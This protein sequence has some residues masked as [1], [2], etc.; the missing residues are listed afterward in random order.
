MIVFPAIDLSDG[1]CVRLSQGDFDRKIVY[2]QDPLAVARGFRAAGAE[3]LHVVDLDGA[4][5]GRSAQTETILRLARDSGLNLQV[6]GGIREK[7][8]L[9]RLLSGGAA[10]VVIGSRA[11]ESPSIVERWLGDVGSDRLVLA[12]DVRCRD[13]GYV[14]A[15]RGWQEESEIS[16][17]DLLSVYEGSVLRHVICTDIERDGMLEGPN[18]VLYREMLERFPALDVLASG[19][20]SSLEDL[21]KLNETGVGG[22][23]VGKAL[24]EERFSF[25]ETLRF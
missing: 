22:V 5:D 7:E 6:G 23:I 1:A 19:G 13:G 12:F 24:Y 3:W 9:E 25:S 20:V 15:T 2:A 10:R 14:P 21:A 8:Q 18:L 4:R 17:W 11:I 16:L